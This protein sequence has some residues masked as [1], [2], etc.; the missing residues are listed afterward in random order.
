MT[1]H[2]S[3]SGLLSAWLG[4]SCLERQAPLA[5][6]SAPPAPSQQAARPLPALPLLVNP[7]PSAVEQPLNPYFEGFAP[8]APP[9]FGACS[10]EVKATNVTA[11]ARAGFRLAELKAFESP[12]TGCIEALVQSL[13][14]PA[15]ETPMTLR[16][17]TAGPAVGATSGGDPAGGT[18]L[19]CKAAARVGC[20]LLLLR[21]PPC[22]AHSAAR[23]QAPPESGLAHLHAP[24]LLPCP[25]SG[26]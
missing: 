22:R 12:K 19:A 25:P 11:Y 7:P 26:P 23:N 20:L 14:L 3:T 6:G 2:P 9:R 8:R 16:S 24:H 13:E 4:H 1:Q 5:S 15:S 21:N 18:S 10:S 17:G